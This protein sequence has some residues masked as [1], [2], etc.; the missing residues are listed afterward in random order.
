MSIISH[1]S[2]GT[3]DFAKSKAFYDAV[4]ATLS[5]P[6]MMTYEGNSAGYGRE[7]PE[8][9]IGM[10]HDGQ[11]AAPGNGWHLCFNAERREQVDAFHEKALQLGGTDEGKPGLRPQYTPDYYAA[12]VRDPDGNKIEAVCFVK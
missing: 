5:I 6:C 1:M 8:F 3:N 12:F 9:W 2:L 7:F 4:L 10:P 11:P